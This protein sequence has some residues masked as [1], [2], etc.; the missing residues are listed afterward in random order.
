[1]II[2]RR[3]EIASIEVMSSCPPLSSSKKISISEIDHIVFIE[4]KNHCTR[5]IT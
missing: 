4:K 3:Q 5:D 1:M 2:G